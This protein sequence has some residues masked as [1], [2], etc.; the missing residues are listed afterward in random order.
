MEGPGGVEGPGVEPLFMPELQPASM[1]S[2]VTPT[3]REE[4]GRFMRYPRPTG[5]DNEAIK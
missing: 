5:D 4:V 3:V 2:A 1:S